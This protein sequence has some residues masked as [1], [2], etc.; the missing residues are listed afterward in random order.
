VNGVYPSGFMTGRR[1]LELF[2]ED[3]PNRNIMHGA[4]MWKAELFRQH[5]FFATSADF[6]WQGGPSSTCGM[7]TLGDVWFID[8][9][10]LI[11][12]VHT[13]AAS[14]QGTQHYHFKQC[15][16]TICAGY[17]YVIADPEMRRLR[18]NTCLGATGAYVGNKIANK[19]GAFRN[20]PLGDLSSM[21]IPEITSDEF[22]DELARYD[23]KLT[24]E[25]YLAIEASDLVPAGVT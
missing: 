25:Q 22:F 14:F 2:A 20:N 1:F 23:I 5:D 15:L 16:A 21:M 4:L 8:E 19:Q 11:N 10:C 7:A 3:Y 13:A 24:Q 6:P 18:D 12:R 9:P 17:A